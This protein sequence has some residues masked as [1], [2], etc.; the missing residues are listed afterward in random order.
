MRFI[1]LEHLRPDVE[2]LIPALNAAAIAVLNEPI[3]ERRA[4]LIEQFRPRWVAF[5]AAFDAFSHGKCWYVECRNP[6]TDDDIDHFRPKAGIYED[7]YHPGYYWLAFEWTNLRLSCHRANRL[8]VNPETG[9]TGGKA[10]H[11]PLVNPAARAWGPHDDW[12]LEVPALLDPTDPRDPAML[13]FKPN[14][15]VDLSPE[16]KG[17]AT[18]EMKFDASRIYL[19]LNW[20]KFRDDR[21]VL[22]NNIVRLIE[23]G[24]REAP[25]S[26]LDMFTASN[27]FIDAVRDLVSAISPQE[28]YSAAARVFV[29]SFKHDLWW[30]R[31]I[32]LRAAA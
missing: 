25:N 24:I 19:H 4:A 6:G 17:N 31:D 2:H 12:R 16:F 32:V 9:E 3:P 22:Y 14:G 27:A 10:G 7:Q 20:P 21:V 23:R 30:V 8:R 13:S 29:E 11:F 18:A 15:E 1:N 5:R 28:P 26:S